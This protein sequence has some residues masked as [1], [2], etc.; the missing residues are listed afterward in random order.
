MNEA[1]RPGPVQQQLLRH[2]GRLPL[3]A[4][5][6]AGTRRARLQRADH[7]RLRGRLGREGAAGRPVAGPLAGPR[8]HG[9]APR[10]QQHRA[11]DPRS[12]CPRT[13]PA[14]WTASPSAP[15]PP[16]WARS[17]PRPSSR[18][19]SSH[20]RPGR[21]R[22]VPRPVV[23]IPRSTSTPRKKKGLP[24]GVFNIIIDP[25]KCKGCAECVT[26]CDDNALKMVDKTDE[27]MT[28]RGRATATSRTSGRATTSTSTT[29][30]SST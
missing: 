8:R 11:G 12:T 15:T 26:V 14:A 21:P 24:G 28:T 7:P 13:A 19:S 1:T 23:A 18:R 9:N 10:L 6:S 5:Q 29:I 3:Q 2:A 20:R 16:S 17:C 22:D 4:G 30:C 27:V 25:S